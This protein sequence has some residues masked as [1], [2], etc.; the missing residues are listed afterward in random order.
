M[1]LGIIPR[2]P[3]Q[4]HT[5]RHLQIN[6]MSSSSRNPSSSRSTHNHTATGTIHHPISDSTSTS[7]SRSPQLNL[8]L[9]QEPERGSGHTNINGHGRYT[10]ND[11][12]NNSNTSNTKVHTNI[13]L[14]LDTSS[15]GGR[16]KENSV[17]RDDNNNSKDSKEGL[18]LGDDAPIKRKIACMAC[19]NIKVSLSSL[20]LALEPVKIFWAKVVQKG[21]DLQLQ[22]SLSL[23]LTSTIASLLPLTTS[24]LVYTTTNPSL[25]PTKTT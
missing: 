15:I 2:I 22:L 19:R 10:H 13:D 5:T 8:H 20:G 23:S 16:S 4:Y 11:I 7:T 18:G 3:L 17:V 21:A 1:K 24:L 12:N 14:N 25:E 6:P 9:K